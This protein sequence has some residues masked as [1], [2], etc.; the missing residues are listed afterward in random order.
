MSFQVFESPIGPLRL[1][2]QD[3]QLSRLYFC[4]EPGEERTDRPRGAEPAP[5]PLLDEACKQLAAYFGGRLK[6][7]TLPLAPAGTPF[8][9]SVWREL[10]RIPHG[11]TS[12][13]KEVA[14]RLGRPGAARAVGLAN[15]RN[16]IAI[17]IPCHRVL[18]ADGKLVGYAG[19]LERKKAL[20]KLEGMLS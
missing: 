19:G 2:E 17:V 20:L 3:G 18:G 11:A 9:Q 12:S 16:P 15:N 7:F 6:V 13:Y 8:M 1:E 5:S 10:L 4:P 14:E